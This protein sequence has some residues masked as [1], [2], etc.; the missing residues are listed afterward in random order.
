MGEDYIE[1]EM[2]VP[3]GNAKRNGARLFE[4]IKAKV[5]ASS[6]PVAGGLAC[7]L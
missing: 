3:A 5:E 1:R 6:A 4:L 2:G 7:A